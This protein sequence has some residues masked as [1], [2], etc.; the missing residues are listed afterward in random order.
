M[1]VK[2][3]GEYKLF[4]QRCHNIT[5]PHYEHLTIRNDDSED[6][7]YHHH[8]EFI[9]EITEDDP[10]LIQDYGITFPVVYFNGDWFLF[11]KEQEVLFYDHNYGDITEK[12]D[13][14]LIWLDKVFLKGN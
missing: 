1:H 13:S 12:W 4:L 10:S 2:F 8:L 11:N 6:S 5:G 7:L 14:F 3:S 9:N